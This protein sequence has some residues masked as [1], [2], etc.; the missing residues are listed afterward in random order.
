MSR[1]IRRGSERSKFFEKGP[2]IN[3]IFEKTCFFKVFGKYRKNPLFQF[4]VKK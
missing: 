2:I 4:F 1:E 3:G